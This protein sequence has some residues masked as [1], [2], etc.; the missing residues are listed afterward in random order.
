MTRSAGRPL[1]AVTT[2]EV[3][4]AHTVT[5]TPE[6]EPAQQEMALGLKY[7]RAVE[8]AGGIPL[9]V[10]PLASGCIEELLDRVDGLCLSG[11]PDLDPIA[12]GDRRHIRLGPV[13][14]ELDQFELALARAA[15]VRGMPILAVCRGMQVLNVAR[16]GTLHQ[17]LPDVTD[18]AID[19]RQTEPGDRPTHWV[20][21]DG[22][23]RVASIMSRKRLKVNSFHHQAVAR[24]GESLVGTSRA[25]DGTIESI[26]ATDRAFL[27]G[28]QWHAECLVGRPEQAALFGAFVGS[29]RR[30]QAAATLRRVA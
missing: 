7:L 8:Q 16:G 3:R 1:I 5:Q 9:V 2:S 17:H 21:I 11:G 6:G 14:T 12:Y 29:A 24:L 10:P 19:H 30:L 20:A 4:A 25:S 15:D 18:G 22:I 23:S 26:E 13:E 28:V 27:I